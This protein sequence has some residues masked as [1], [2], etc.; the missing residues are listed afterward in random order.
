MRT[1]TRLIALLGAAAFVGCSS[2][3]TGSEPPG[4]EPLEPPAEG[5]GIQYRM[6]T[7]IDPGQE[8]EKCQLFV[9]P[10]EGLNI[11]RDAVR[12]NGGS[13]HVLLFTTA[14]SEIPATTIR[15]VA[16]DASQVHDCKDGP[17]ADWTVTGVVSGSQSPDGKSLLGDLPE[18][19]AVK[20]APGTVL[21]MNTHYLNTAPEPMET[22]A[23]IN[24]YTIPDEA[25][26]TEAG[27]LFHYNP[28][29]HIP[30]RGEASA[31][32]R[33]TT[34]EDISVVRVQSHMH[35]RGVGYAAHKVSAGG[36][37]EQIYAHDKWEDV[38]IQ[39]FSPFLE[40]KAGESLDFRC[41]YTNTEARDVIQ[42]STTK[43]EMCMLIGPYFP[44]SPAYETCRAQDGSS[45]GTWFGTGTATCAETLECMSTANPITVD[46][47]AEFFSCVVNSCEGASASVSELTN[48]QITGG[49]GE[50][51]QECSGED[52]EA[53]GACV[54]EA[55]APAVEACQVAACD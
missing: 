23:R 1:L 42:G 36:A 28:F 25:V 41:D 52:A 45:F 47:G 39:D 10:P 16:L 20:V 55:C 4:V 17:Q 22:D 3:D 33:C 40:L 30:A 19:V 46:R 43:D 11:Q 29:I 15:G 24:L 31:R 8:I 6:V 37:M 9:A 2:S 38:P 18:G 35:R 12:Y 21:V 13:H 48:C 26:E 44:R 7:T 32:M 14:Y 49:Y 34:E 27:V 5:A 51:E 50:C 54:E 53:C